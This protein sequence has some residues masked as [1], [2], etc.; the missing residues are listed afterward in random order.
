MIKCWDKY[1]YTFTYMKSAVYLLDF[2]SHCVN[3]W[4]Y[5]EVIPQTLYTIQT[6][7]YKYLSPHFMFTFDE[8]STMMDKMV[9][10]QVTSIPQVGQTAT[11]VS[12]K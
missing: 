7:V 8:R 5:T 1:L 4:Q 3:K 10:I 9:A 6:K 11:I 12:S 2:I